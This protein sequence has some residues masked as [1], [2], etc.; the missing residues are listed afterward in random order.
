MNE[1]TEKVIGACIEVHRELG[2][3][4]PES[5]YEAAL[6]IEFRQRGLSFEQQKS[7]E[8]HYKGQTVGQFRLDFLVAG[9]LIIELKS[10]ECLDP[11]HVRQVVA[12][13]HQTGLS[14]GLL[15]NFN[16]RVL[17]SGGLRRVVP[18]EQ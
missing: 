6:A 10:V 9:V 17:T 16:V 4:L 2:P 11:V 12:Y 1:L 14:L 7:V 5:C 13:L 15:I 8:T 3:G 18:S